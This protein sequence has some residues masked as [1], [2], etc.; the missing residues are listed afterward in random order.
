M[1]YSI[2]T[3]RKHV[4]YH[5]EMD[6]P[7]G[8]PSQQVLGEQPCSFRPG[9]IAFPT[10]LQDIL[11]NSWR[12]CITKGSKGATQICKQLNCLLGS[13]CHQSTTSY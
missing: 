9:Q 10:F 13:E 8:I 7:V 12:W 1:G 6:I 3:V 11:L 4:A 5:I 2:H